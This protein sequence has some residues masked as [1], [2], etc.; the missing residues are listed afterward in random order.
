MTHLYLLKVRDGPPVRVTYENIAIFDDHES[1]VTGLK[2]LEEVNLSGSKRRFKLISTS[3]DKNLVVR[4]SKFDVETTLNN[5]K[6]ADSFEVLRKE[7]YE[8][9]I[10]A[11]DVTKDCGFI[12]TGHD[13]S[14]QL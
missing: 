2:L 6:E 7:A 9:R 4:Q 13:K 3:T 12:L 8:E 1:T 5:F 11:M 10:N 14:I